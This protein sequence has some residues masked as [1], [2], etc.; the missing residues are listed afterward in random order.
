MFKFMNW[1]VYREAKE[2]FSMV[3]NLV[4]KLPSQYRYDLGNQ[5]IRSSFSIILNIAEGSGKSSDKEMNRFI[6]ISLG[7]VNETLAALDVMKDNKF[8][9]QNDFDS[10]YSKLES[11]SKQLGGFKKKLK[12]S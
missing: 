6:N 4:K 12:E 8:I 3:M 9:N 7:S 11:I 1:P 2:L 10:A 5:V